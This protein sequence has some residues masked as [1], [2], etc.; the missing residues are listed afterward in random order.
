MTSVWL[1]VFTTAG[2]ETDALMDVEKINYLCT[3]IQRY[4]QDWLIIREYGQK[5]DHPHLNVVFISRKPA[6]DASTFRKGFK[7]WYDGMQFTRNTLCI[8]PAPE[9]VLDYLSKEDNAEIIS[10]CGAFKDFSFE[11]H[12]GKYKIPLDKKPSR[13]KFLSKNQ[14]RDYALQW[15]EDNDYKIQTYE[16]YT[17]MLNLWRKD[18]TFCYEAMRR[19]SHFFVQ[20]CDSDIAEN[21][22]FKILNDNGLKMD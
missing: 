11:P 17:N 4:S 10:K 20:V 1:A 16:D 19:P 15:M 13:S 22:F 5:G 2:T 7:T 3:F 9:N 14:F 8:K 21:L 18:G 6:K 12:R